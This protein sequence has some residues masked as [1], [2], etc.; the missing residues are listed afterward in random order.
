MRGAGATSSSAGGRTRT[1]C[2]TGSSSGHCLV[3]CVPR[4]HRTAPD[5]CGISPSSISNGARGTRRCS[6]IRMVPRSRTTWRDDRA[7]CSS[8]VSGRPRPCHVARQTP[9]LTP[10]GWQGPRRT[11]RVPSLAVRL[12]GLADEPGDDDELRLRKRVGVLAGYI[13]VVVPLPSLSRRAGR[14]LSRTWPGPR[15]PGRRAARCAPSARG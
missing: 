1:S 13:L 14:G 2:T 10:D 5:A 9:L 3:S 12:I 7:P 11:R 8:A 15:A 4:A 6:S